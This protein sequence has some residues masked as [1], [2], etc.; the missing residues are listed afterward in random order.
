MKPPITYYGG[1]QKMAS[2]ILPLIPKHN[3]YC[4]PFFGGGAIFFMKPPSELE[5][6]NDTNGDLINFF[7][8]M[9]NDFRKLNKEIKT[10]LYAR[11]HHKTAKVILDNPKL[12]SDVKRAW[13]IWVMAHQSYASKLDG[14]WGYDITINTSPKRLANKRRAFP[15]FSKRLEQVQIECNDALKVITSRD[16]K[17]SF[18]YCDPPYYNSDMGH[19][20]GYTKD[21]FEKLLQTLSKIKG[22]F[23]L[24][25]YPS[26][27]IANY[28]KKNKWY[29][30][31]IDTAMSISSARFETK[32]RKTEVLTA[33][34]P[35]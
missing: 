1:K 22:K 21:D 9:K 25:S 33:N 15:D 7:R 2:K 29:T 12:F 5:V 18:F 13:A 32:K 4:E 6:I 34:Y 23:L 35:I 26:D 16:T 19:Y 27:I 3:L 17:A 11:E 14:P 20:K 24:S 31:K 10:T 30:Q 8:V 28:S